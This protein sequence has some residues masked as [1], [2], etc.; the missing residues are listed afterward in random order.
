MFTK[1]FFVYSKCYTCSNTQLFS[2]LYLIQIFTKDPGHIKWR[3]VSCFCSVPKECKCYGP[4]AVAIKQD[5]PTTS[6][7]GLPQEPPEMDTPSTFVPI[8]DI[9]D[10]LIGKWCIVQYDGCLYPGIIQDVDTEGCAFVKTMNCIGRTSSNRFF[11]PSTDDVLW[12][13]PQDVLGLVPEPQPVTKRHMML[14]VNVWEKLCS[15][16]E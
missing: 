16:R 7:E 4:H 11:W 3:D 6:Q 15:L 1:L 14:P 12:Y 2:F 9:T 8:S 5:G 13:Q 10:Q